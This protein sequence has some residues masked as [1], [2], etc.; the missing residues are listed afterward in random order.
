MNIS[1]PILHLP[2]TV[3]PPIPIP[4][5]LQQL[6]PD[7]IKATA[8]FLIPAELLY[9][10]LYFHSKE[11]PKWHAWLSGLALGMLWAAPV[12]APVGCGAAKCLQ[13][14]GSM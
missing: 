4:P 2:I 3:I 1:H 5:P 11:L 12:L 14:F 10:S 8:Y 9:F 7:F 6:V 13:H